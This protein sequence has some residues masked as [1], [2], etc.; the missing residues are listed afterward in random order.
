MCERCGCGVANAGRR[1]ADAVPVT[2][3]SIPVRIVEPSAQNALAT[4]RRQ[5]R[6]NDPLLQRASRS[7]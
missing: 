6:L 4:R 5:Q 3:A 2:L 7:P 1:T